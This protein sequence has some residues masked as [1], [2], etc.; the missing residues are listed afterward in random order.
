[1]AQPIIEIRH[2]TK[3]YTLFK[4]NKEQFLSIFYRS[5]K[6]KK[7]LALD[8]V[9]FSVEKGESVGII[10]NNGAGKSTILKTITGV[11]FPTSGQVEV[12]GR[13]AALLELTAGFEPEMTGR[14]NIYLKGYILGL[15]DEYIHTIEKKVIEF[16]Q[17]GD[18][19]DQPV[20]TYSSG[21]KMRLGFSININTDPEILVV[22][23]ALS[24]GDN[25]FKKKCKDA[26]KDLIARGT[27][28]LYVSHNADSVQEVCRRAIYLKKGKLVFDG[29]VEEALERYR[30]DN[31]P[32]TAKGKKAPTPAERVANARKALAEKDKALL[33]A[34][35]EKK[36][37]E[38]ELAAAEQ[39]E[40]LA[41]KE[42]AP[43]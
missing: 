20:R 16:A 32:K 42:S 22:D 34:A 26:I 19:I 30:V 13:V 40:A 33:K 21:M 2:V 31:P 37:A 36:A 41:L 29:P 35:A 15:R 27:T 9:T 17:L 11:T 6:L 10:G 28:V 14:E 5:P 7:H 4:N 18:Y 39:A 8:D 43:V 23:E 25:A 38:E 24:V 1:M 3:I 12:R